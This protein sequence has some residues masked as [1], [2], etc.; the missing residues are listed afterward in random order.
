M[1]LDQLL[2]DF[3]AAHPSLGIET[4]YITQK[5]D[6]VSGEI[7]AAIRA[8]PLLDPETFAL[9]IGP[10]QSMAIVAA[11]AY[12][13]DAPQ[14]D[15]PAHLATHSGICFA[16]DGARHLAPC[17]MVGPDGPFSAMPQ[18]RMISNDV[19][20]LLMHARSGLGLA[21]VFRDLVRQDLAEGT[22][23]EVL[24]GQAAPLSGFSLNYL[25][26]RNMPL[27]LQR[28]ADFSRLTT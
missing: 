22:L 17:V 18:P 15:S 23:V 13:Q 26:K 25:S 9:P 4:T 3:G 24:K 21:Y 8:E 27:R 19:S 16:I 6:L 7:D 2:A 10:R 1:F 12:L 14:L 11:P 20:S 28:F 5:A